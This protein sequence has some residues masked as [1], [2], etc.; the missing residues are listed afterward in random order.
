MAEQNQEADAVAIDS[1]D[2]YEREPQTFPRLS[3][4]QAAASRAMKLRSSS[5]TARWCS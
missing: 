1:A 4:E 5:P 2:P 3:E